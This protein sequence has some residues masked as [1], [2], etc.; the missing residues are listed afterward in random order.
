[1]FEPSV[2]Y[3]SFFFWFCFL[4]CFSGPLANEL[5]LRDFFFRER[6]GVLM[7]GGA[8][9]KGTRGGRVTW[10]GTSSRGA[11]HTPTRV[12]SN[13]NMMAVVSER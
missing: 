11:R 5:V 4:F 7:R 9:G 2:P 13:D 8:G 1:M 6:L 10:R 12:S 3:F